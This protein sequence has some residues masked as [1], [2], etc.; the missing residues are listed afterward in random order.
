MDKP[1]LQRSLVNRLGNFMGR[2][3]ETATV[4]DWYNALVLSLRDRLM[5][6]WLRTQRAYQEAGAKRVYYLSLEY[7]I[8]RNLSNSALCLDIDDAVREVISEVGFDLETLCEIEPDAGLG[9]GGLGRLAACYLDS[10]ATLQLPGFGYGIRYDY[11]IFTQA[12]GADGEQIERPNTWLRFQHLWEQPREELR[13]PVRFGGRVITQTDSDGS[14]HHQWVDG[15]EVIAVAYDLPVPGY[16]NDTVNHLRLWSAQAASDFNLSLFNAGQHA[17]AM[18]EMNAAEHLSQVLYP[19][20]RTEQ[21]RELRLRQQY[22]FVA[23]SLQDILDSYLQENDT[24]DALPDKVAIQLN[25]THPTLAVPEL[26]RICIDEHGYEWEKAWEITRGVFSYTNH[27]LLPEALEKW[28][29]ASFE[30]LFPRHL[31]IIYR[32]NRELMTAVAKQY[33]NDLG[34]LQRMSVIDEGYPRSVR[35]ANLA[36]VGSHKINGVAAIHSRLM[37]ET[38]FRDFAEFYPDRFINVTNGIT[39]R[40]WLREANPM[41]AQL[42]DGHIDSWDTDLER[43]AQLAPLADDAGFRER[44]LAVKQHNKALLARYI[45]DQLGESILIDSMYDVQIKRIHEYKRQLLNLLYVITRYRRLRD[46]PALDLPPRTVI[47]SGKAAPAY[48]MARQ[49]LK[50]INNVAAVIN[51]DPVTADRLKVIVIPDYSVSVAQRIIP[52]ADLSQQISTAGMEA[53]GTGNMKLALNG[54]ITIGTLDGANVEI[55]DAVGEDNIFIFGLTAEEVAAQRT[56]GYRPSEIV[57]GNEELAAVLSAIAEGHFSPHRPNQFVDL[58]DALQRDGEHFLVLADYEAYV[59]C[60][61]KVDNLYRDPD[62]W[63]RMAILNM[64]RVGRFSSDRAIAEYAEKVWGVTP[65]EPH[66]AS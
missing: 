16:Q 38:V 3:S 30:R 46:N 51:N 11:G 40:R 15:H 43:L 5:T 22:F 49:I 23:A 62:A 57:A 36:I 42:A 54:A 10:M 7:L 13:Y 31:E 21:G 4:R 12:F 26:M 60:Q 45:E 59:A 27:T 28:P 44:F 2:D 35:M 53:S 61:D 37:V 19:D 25:D 50:L 17:E 34:R 58:I 47:F 39:P 24:L 56:S 32:I 18:A 20:D 55:R 63:A 48:M 1:G 6:R 64:C 65:I 33:D 29:V 14:T 66:A 52:A 41:L 8:G 9:N